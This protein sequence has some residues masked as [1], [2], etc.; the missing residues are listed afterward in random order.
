MYKFF[1]YK[2][3]IFRIVCA[4][5]R[6]VTVVPILP[7]YISKDAILLMTKSPSFVEEANANP[8]KG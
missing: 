1:C 8:S 5:I 7:H 6:T 4:F 2:L 3:I